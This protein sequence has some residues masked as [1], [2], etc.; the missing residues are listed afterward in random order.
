MLIC[1]FSRIQIADADYKKAFEDELGAFKGRIRH[2]A[3]EKHQEQLEE[4]K[5]EEEEERKARLGPGGLDPVEVFE[6]LPDV[7][8]TH[9]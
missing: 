5:R 6:S 4:A 7:S 2:R 3:E 1:V 9:E 8:S